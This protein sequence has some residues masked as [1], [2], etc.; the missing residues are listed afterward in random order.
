MLAYFPVMLLSAVVTGTLNGVIAGN[1]VI[2]L[3]R[4]DNAAK[5]Q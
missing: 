5:R 2:Y 4:A 1:T 3:K